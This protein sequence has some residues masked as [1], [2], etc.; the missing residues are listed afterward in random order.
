MVPGLRDPA[1]SVIMQMNSQ[2]SFLN[3]IIPLLR[4]MKLMNAKKCFAAAITMPGV[5]NYLINGYSGIINNFSFLRP[6]CS[7]RKFLNYNIIMCG[8]HNSS[9]EIPGNME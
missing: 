7:C 3:Y 9:A 1:I 5:Q 6:D 8:H 4:K 2:K